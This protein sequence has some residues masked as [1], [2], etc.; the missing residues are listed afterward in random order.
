VGELRAW[1][2][3]ATG[4]VG[5]VPTMGAL[6]AGHAALIARARAECASVVVSI[7]V[8]PTQF[9]DATDLAAYPQPLQADLGLCRATGA[10]A[11]WLPDRGEL[12]ADGYHYRVV[13]DDLA[14]ILEGASRP[15]HFSGVLT[16]VLK[17]L[18]AL[19]PDCAYFGE[20][21]WQQLQLVR[22][23]A[24]AF[25]L[26]TAI[27]ACPT[28][29]DADGLALSS[30]NARLSPAGRRQAAQF[31]RLLRAA[32]DA[33]TA[34]SELEAAG[35]LVDYVADR[36]NRR[37]AAIIHEGVRLIDNLMTND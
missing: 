1:R 35:F 6:H 22:G 26:R 19:E 34:R 9:N 28:V 13:E 3:R 25:F 36:D 24:Q 18:L 33:E 11:V 4:P 32:A 31:P 14:N 37:L 27:I 5:F 23:M 17:L 12:Y 15:G 30:R 20:K 29:R 10:D 8:N 7:F 16:V 2:A 21:D